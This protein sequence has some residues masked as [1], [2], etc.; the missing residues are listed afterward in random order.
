[1]SLRYV[2]IR[3]KDR[4]RYQE[5]LAALEKKARYPLGEDSFTIEHGADYFAF[6][7]RLGTVEYHA[8]LDGD[9]VVAVGCGI[10]R[11]VPRRTWY[12]C[13][14]KVDPEYRGRRIPLAM[15]SRAFLPNYLRCPRGY[16]ISMNPA[17]GENRVVRLLQKFRWARITVPAYLEI[18]SLDDARMREVAPVVERHRGP[19]SYLSLAGKKDLV[20]A[21]T[22][23]PLPLMHVQFGPCAEAGAREPRDG[24]AHMLCAPGGDPLAHALAERGIAPTATAS[25]VQHRMSWSDW[26]FVLTSDV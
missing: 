22:G 11:R 8:A 25:I 10:L 7:D 24:H 20:L 21:S 9:R 19:I 6:F 16:A 17:K 2:R 18:Y 26:R 15:L 5:P 4:S 3:R 13:D 12:L 23:R 1:M 14:L